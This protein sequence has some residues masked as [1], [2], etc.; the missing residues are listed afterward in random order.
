MDR[1]SGQPQVKLSLLG[2]FY[3]KKFDHKYSPKLLP[4]CLADGNQ[5]KKGRRREK[6]GGEFSILGQVYCI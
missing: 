3:F 4:S 1:T 2:S 6:G 5:E